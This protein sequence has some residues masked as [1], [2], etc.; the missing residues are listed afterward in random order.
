MSP[1]PDSRRCSTGRCGKK[2]VEILF[3]YTNVVL[4]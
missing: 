4:K 2:G 1:L 3:A